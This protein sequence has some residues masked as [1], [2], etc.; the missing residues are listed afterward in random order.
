MVIICSKEFIAPQDSI[1]DNSENYFNTFKFPLSDFQKWAIYSIIKGDHCLITAHTGSGKTLPAE[2]AI[3]YF[4]SKN[5]KV[6]YT[7]PIKALCNQKLYDFKNKFPHI[8]FGILTGDIKDNPDADVLIMTTEILRNTLLNRK[9]NTINSKPLELHFNLNIECDLGAV[10]FDEVH[11]IGD[12]ERGVVW[13][14]SIMLLPSHVQ[15]IMLSATID[16][17]NIFAE[18]VEKQKN[19]NTNETNHKKNLYLITTHERVVPLTHYLWTTS[20]SVLA[21]PGVKGTPQEHKFKE[22][23]NKPIVIASNDG[24]FNDINYFKTEKIIDFLFKNKVT[25][26]RPYVLNELVNY[27]NINNMLPALCFVFSRKNVEFYAKEIS[28]NL[29]TKEDTIPNI[30]E[31]ECQKILMAKFKNYKEYILLEEYQ[32]VIALLKKGIA[33]HHAGIMP[34]IREMVELLFE[35]RYIK[36]LFATETFAV[37]INMPTKTVVFTSLNKFSGSKMR[38]LLP[39][40]YTQMAGR[41]GRRGIDTIGHVIHCANLFK[42]PEINTYREMLTGPPKMLSSQFKIS[43]NLILNMNARN[44]TNSDNNNLLIDEILRFMNNSFVQN[45]IAKAIAYYDKTQNELQEK[46]KAQEDVINNKSIVKTPIE[47]INKFN[48]LT[49]NSEIVNNKQKKKLLQSIHNLK[50]EYSSIE[51]D[52]VYYEQ[53][54]QTKNELNNNEL[55]RFDTINHI[56]NNIK[57]I[58]NVLKTN[59]FLE[60]DGRLTKKGIVA[61]NI[62]EIHPLVFGDMYE[63]CD[64]NI[65]ASELVG[66]LS[67]FTNISISDDLRLSI[68]GNELVNPKVK[69]MAKSLNSTMTK[70]YNIE[71]EYELN[72]G[73]DFNLHFELI[74]Y[75]IEWCNARDETKCHELITDMKTSKELFLG[76]FIKCIL[77]INNIAK[78]LETVCTLLENFSLLQK[79]K[80][81]PE[82]TLK[83]V[84][85]NQSLY[86]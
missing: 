63:T 86:I 17:P 78:E 65:S 54:K 20:P 26:K 28:V 24:V 59:N 15:L 82:L 32:S 67:C 71:D 25:V 29:F 43:F 11:Y 80:Q 10:I 19:S 52:L 66:L 8:S 6:I 23:M 75:L 3:E 58:I 69:K 13:E 85:T 68:P 35:K 34:V 73:A 9:I 50:E 77:K 31:H 38:D 64:F 16:S 22:V 62:Q 14:Q 84:V 55:Y 37:G 39:H 76:E 27:L 18:W 47:I 30:I 72:S 1:C 7:G 36:L 4:K 56:E 40:E 21:I 48:E 45:D 2:F 53:L 49:T 44:N 70:Y 51:N 5:K 12:T 41:A 60:E 81:I 83:Y 57:H 33:I 74:D 46:K 79:V 61:M 42:L